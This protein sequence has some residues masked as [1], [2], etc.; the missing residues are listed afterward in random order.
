MGLGSAAVS[1]ALLATARVLAGTADAGWV[2]ARA[3][4]AGIDDLVGLVAEVIAGAVLGW[5]GL[6]SALTAAARIPGLTGR[7]AAR[8]ALRF[9]PSVVTGLVRVGVGLTVA[10]TPA[11]ATPPASAAG[12][13]VASH[14]AEGGGMATAALPGV[15]RP[16]ETPVRAELM[17][18]TNANEQPVPPDGHSTGRRATMPDAVVVVAGDCLWTIAA[19]AIGPDATDAEIA[20]TW[21]RWYAHNRGVV[22][23]D[24]DLL[25]PGTVL[26]PP[27]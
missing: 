7:A 26:R 4:S 19:R 22:G 10:S 24:P 20:A 23:A 17:G 8:I 16:G 14:D 15:G 6:L 25:I 12:G 13:V 27:E 1:V 11:M 18:S 3:G 2:T 21:P 5:V 9:A